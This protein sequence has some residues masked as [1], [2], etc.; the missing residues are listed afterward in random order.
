MEW[1]NIR[2]KVRYISC[3]TGKFIG[4]ANRHPVISFKEKTGHFR[5]F[6]GEQWIELKV[7]NECDIK[8]VKEMAERDKGSL[9]LKVRA[10]GHGYILDEE[11]RIHS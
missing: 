8:R 7:C 9:Y 11:L 3:G 2:I 10:V 6:D 1:N 4:V 5:I